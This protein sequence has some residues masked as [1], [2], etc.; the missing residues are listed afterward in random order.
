MNKDY[1]FLT[2]EKM[3]K[4][5][6]NMEERL[7]T[8]R[9]G[10]ANPNMLDN[11]YVSYYGTP[12]QIKQ[13]ATISVPEARQINIKPFD[14]SILGAIEK[15]I[16]EAN[17][18]ITPN[19]NGESV[20]ITIPPLTEERRR[21]LVKQTKEY[22]EDGR[23]AIRNIRRD[24]L[25]ELKKDGLSED[26]S[27]NIEET[28]V[29]VTGIPISSR[30]LQ[31]HN[32]EQTINDLGFSNFKPIILFFGGGEYG[33]G[34]SH[35]LDVFECLV[36]NFD[37]YQIIAIAGKNEK[38]SNYD[39]TNLSKDAGDGRRGRKKKENQAVSDFGGADGRRDAGDAD[40][41]SGEGRE[42]GAS[43][44]AAR[45]GGA[46]LSRRAEREQSAQDRADGDRFLRFHRAHGAQGLRLLLVW[47][48][49][50]SGGQFGRDRAAA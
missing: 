44:G 40:A 45:G 43:A 29:F 21:E 26:V 16:F 2:K 22:A 25:D 48:N 34:N 20:F 17:L 9:A 33:L 38:R 28:K 46:G 3:N 32:D 14:K 8:I 50:L 49:H 37:N 13:L 36:K 7:S 24:I 1:I 18:G 5:I 42:P 12:T 39:C 30:F 41:L 47:R 23:I 4:A 6:E 31:A 27:K 19:N 10:R 11:V 35:T 15:A